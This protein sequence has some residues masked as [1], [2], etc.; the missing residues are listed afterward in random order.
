VRHDL[1]R[2]RRFNRLLT[3]RVGLLD[4]RYLR[5][6]LPFA[7]ARL[8]YEVAA[9][10]PLATNHLRRLI[11]VDAGALSRGLAVL[12]AR[13]LVRRRVEPG[14]ARNRVV[15]VTAQGI[16]LLA[17]LDVRADD[18]VSAMIAG[19]AAGERRRLLA[20]VD[21]ARRLLVGALLGIERRAA[22]DPDVR[23]AQAAYL[24]EIARRL[25][26][27]LDAWNQGVLAP[28]LSL[29]V[30]DGR[31]PVG[32][33]LL[34]R[35]RPGVGEIKRMWLHP[36]VRG[37]GL[38]VRLLGALE[39]AARQAGNREVRLDTNER[40]LEAIALY[41][42]AGYRRIPRYNDNPDA[43]HFYAKAFG[44]RR[45]RAGARMAR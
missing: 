45:V 42:A 11:A 9:L 15:E 13:R 3:Q 18:R 31:R 21:E 35:F 12:E 44:A 10:A 29:L 41:E 24:A 17:R 1:G 39:D 43:T 14:N 20:V 7:Q 22:Q 28:A 40:L 37:L 6:P 27:P 2:L 4:P 30:V 33:G 23:A 19:L 8:L 34:R 26:R 16:G 5:S 38:G 32:C 25:G 36:D